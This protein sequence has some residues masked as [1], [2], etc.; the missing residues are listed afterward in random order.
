MIDNKTFSV[1]V[2]CYNR[3]KTIHKVLEAWRKQAD[4][5]F[6]CDCT[7]EGVPTKL[8]INHVRFNK[9]PGNKAR[10][11]I[12]TLTIGDFVI[13]ADDDV[14]PKT[15]FLKDL[16]NGWKQVGGGD[17]MVGLLGRKFNNDDYYKC[18]FYRSGRIEKPVEVGFV[19]GIYFTPRKW[20]GYDQKGMKNTVD[21]LFWEM[22]IFPHAKKWVVP[23]KNFSYLPGSKSGMF[24]QPSL[25]K[26][27]K[28]FYK[29]HYNKHYKGK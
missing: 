28:L 24:Q 20:I 21:D 19:G 11:A 1:V 16:Y 12:A 25:R 15:G 29:R 10:H 23:S 27:R 22:K 8:P 18:P 2:V 7:P 9:D 14:V 17:N 5:I 3:Q 26:Y 13:L 4:E 6:F